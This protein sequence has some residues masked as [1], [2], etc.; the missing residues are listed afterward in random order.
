MKQQELLIAFFLLDQPELA[1]LFLMLKPR[2][3]KFKDQNDKSKVKQPKVEK[4]NDR[5][6]AT[7]IDKN[8]VELIR[9]DDDDRN[10]NIK[11]EE[12]KNKETPIDIKTM[13]LVDKFREAKQCKLCYSKCSSDAYLKRHEE[14]VHKAH[15]TELA[16]T[17]ITL[18]DLKF[19]CDW[20]PGVKFLSES[21]LIVHAKI[22]HRKNLKLKKT[23][24]IILKCFFCEEKFING[25]KRIQHCLKIHGKKDEQVD[26]TSIKCM[27]C[28]Q[29]VKSDNIKNHRAVYHNIHS[30]RGKCNLCHKTFFDVKIHNRRAHK[31]E[32]AIFSKEITEGDLKFECKKCKNK[33]LSQKILRTHLNHHNYKDLEI[34]KTTC[35]D[36]DT[37]TYKCCLCFTNIPSSIA[38]I[39]RHALCYHKD[40]IDQMKDPPSKNVF[41]YK[42]PECSLKVFSEN[43]V[44]VHRLIEHFAIDS[45]DLT[46]RFCETSF[47]TQT[48]ALMHRLKIHKDDL[49]LFQATFSIEDK[50]LQCKFCD[51]KYF[52]KSSLNY[53]IRNLHK[54]QYE[55]SKNIKYNIKK[56]ITKPQVTCALCYI[57]VSN[58]PDRYLNHKKKYHANELHLFDNALDQFDL[59]FDCSKCDKKFISLNSMKVHKNIH[60]VELTC[61]FCPEKIQGHVSLVEHCKI[62]HG[63]QDVS[64]DS[65][66][67]KCMGCGKIIRKTNLKEHRMTHNKD[68]LF[69]CQLCHSKFTTQSTLSR[70]K[71]AVHVSAEEMQLLK[72]DSLTEPV[73]ACDKCDYKFYTKSLLEHHYRQHY[74]NL[75]SRPD[76]KDQLYVFKCNL[77]Y[78]KFGKPQNLKDHRE[79]VH[80]SAEERA[81]FFVDEIKKSLLKEECSFCDKKFFNFNSMK[82]HKQYAHKSEMRQETIRNQESETSCEICGKVF[83][84]KYRK[85]LRRHMK[86]IHNIID[87]EVKAPTFKKPEKLDTV[88]NFNEFLNSL[89]L[90]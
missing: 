12:P 62:I 49:E 28:N 31:K 4:K 10:K 29:I 78:Q 33:F 46:C 38:S 86:T 2:I 16:L 67:S 43:S 74:Y 24:T 32:K 23:L 7:N 82:H 37:S 85:H 14:N 57:K 34:L 22:Q 70:H 35:F 11:K 50:N 76:L 79:R 80:I 68:R 89:H 15:Q 52:I 3:D 41:Q 66:N 51:K 55:K 18:N 71:R 40:E 53:H 36:K 56:K 21:I 48:G 87:F 13:N 8:N 65:K 39:S 19:A 30:R 81:L 88:S 60:Q 47:K 17:K 59:A 58:R 26:E 27:V 44:L 1:E 75:D 54:H 84:W 90:K 73:H 20:C 61:F 5:I 83:R 63:K 9:L 69:E 45:D 72:V 64:I 6:V 42:C 77:C 25:R